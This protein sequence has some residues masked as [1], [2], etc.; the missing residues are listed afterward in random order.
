MPSRSDPVESLADDDRDLYD[1]ATWEERTSLDGLS[2]ALHWL[3]TRSAKAL[4]V[5]VALLGLLAI[6]GSFGLGL[7]FDPAVAILVGLSAVPALGLAA[8]VY[9]SDVTTGEPLSLLVATFLLSILTATF[10]A[11]L[12]SFAQPYFDPFGFPG[13]VLFFFV[14]VGPIE[15]SVKLL[16]VRL[17]AY[18]DAR[19]DAVIDGAVYGA[20]AGLG[21]VVIENLVYI[22]RT[23]ELAE[24]SIGIAALGAGDGIAGIRAL[25]GPGHVIYSGFA[26][27]YLGLAKFNPENRGPII[28]KGLVLAAAIHALYNTLVG[29]VTGIASA[30]IGLP[31]VVALFGFV[32]VFQGTFGYVLLRKIRRYRDTYLDTRDELAPEVEPELTEFEQ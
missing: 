3:I 25:A 30:L 28:V 11:V 18:T 17:Y 24:L 12:N 23:V 1:I 10:A 21:F 4:V 31:Q 7:V 27:Y 19:F 26:G 14:I 9:L 16:A 32:V 22:A 5:F 13:L 15:E 20:I 8:Y 2:V 29:P 6:L